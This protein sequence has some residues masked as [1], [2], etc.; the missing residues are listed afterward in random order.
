MLAREAAQ[1]G[2]DIAVQAAS[3]LRRGMRLIVMDVDSTLIQGEVIEMLAAHAGC[4]AEVAGSPSRRCAARSTSPRACAIGWRCSRAGRVRARHGVRRAGARSRRP[5]HR[6]RAQAARLPVRHSQRRLL[7][8]HRPARRG[9]R[10]STSPWPTSSRWSTASSPDGSSA[11]VIDR[12]GKADALR[13]FAEPSG[14][15]VERDDR[16]RR[17]GQRPRHA[18]RGRPRNRLQRQARRAGGRAHGRQRAVHGRDPL[19]AR[20]QPGGGRRRR[21]RGRHRDAR[22][23]V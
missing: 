8:A 18:R 21:R 7:P 10:T 16:H 22:A 4:E 17:R 14:V 5:D 11:P 1:Q 6:A 2:V 13:R 20:N 19:P 15:T 12:A 23:P 3:L 9:A